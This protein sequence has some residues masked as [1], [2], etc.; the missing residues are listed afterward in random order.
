MTSVKLLRLGFVVSVMFYLTGCALLPGMSME[1]PTAYNSSAPSDPVTPEVVPIS[2][3]VIEKFTPSLTAYHYQIGSGD[4]LNIAAWTTNGLQVS[5][6]GRSL[7]SSGT[8]TA[9][10]INPSVNIQNPALRAVASSSTTGGYFVNSD[11]NIFIPILGSVHVAGLTEDQTNQLLENKLQPF[12]RQPAVQTTVISFASQQAF[13]LG[14]INGGTTTNANGMATSSM[15]SLPIT[16]IPLT[17]ATALSQAGG[18]N[19]STANTRLIYVIRQGSLTHP[20]VYW[21][22]MESPASLLYAEQF[23]LRNNDVVYVSTAG[24]AHF[25]RVL[26]QLLPAIQTIWFT[27]SVVKGNN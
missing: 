16:G 7:P 13:I 15:M 2:P 6:T 14:E 26:N 1:N 17:L 5:L 11:G 20:T 21:L 19:L 18:M 22:N 27:Q 4:T 9:M 23:P 3:Q 8:Q 25:N 24:I 12:I 10:A